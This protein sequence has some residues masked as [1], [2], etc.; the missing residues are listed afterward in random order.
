MSVPLGYRLWNKEKTKIALAAELV[1]QAMKVVG[2]KR[3]VLLLYDSWYPKAEVVD[4]VNQFENLE[5]ICNVRVDTVLFDLPPARTGK[6]GRPKKYGNRLELENIPLSKPKTG[7]WLIGVRPVITK[8]WKDKVVYALVTAPK[9]GKGSRRLFLCTKNPKEISFDLKRCADETIH[10][11]GQENKLYLPLAWYGLRWKIEVSYY[12]E[13]TFW[14]LEEYRIRSKQGMEHL[15]NLIFLSYSAMT[16]LPYSDETFSGYQSAS[17]QETKYEIGQQ[18]QATII[19]Y[20]FRKF[21][22]TVKNSIALI[23]IVEN[24]ILSGFKKVQKL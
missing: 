7:N 14:S 12:E 20:S 17:T 8:L 13:K 3:Q 2:S 1:Q 11:Y 18:I 22:E 16:L 24:Y 23:K 19:F 6:R 5:L 21:L 4:L 10:Q 9:T 15:V